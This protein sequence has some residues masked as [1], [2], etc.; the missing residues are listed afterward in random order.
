MSTVKERPWRERARSVAL[1]RSTD[2]A[3][4]FQEFYVANRA[5]LLAF[6]TRRALDPDVARD[7]TAETFV[8]ALQ[9]RHQFRGHTDAEAEAW[10]FAIARTQLSV[11]WR[12]GT[13]ERRALALLGAA[14][15][16]AEVTELERIEELA[17]LRDLRHDV[18]RALDELSPDQAY[19][20]LQRVVDE[21]AY[22]DLAAEL[23]VSEDV[24]RARVSRGLRALA[25]GTQLRDAA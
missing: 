14:T 15:Q 18:R 21:R 3:E 24:V 16:P 11:Y 8:V 7:L 10:L 22:E 17:G 4:A 2:D 9:R 19:A 25:A 5:R 20:V 1:V 12:R 13:A 23:G 6:L